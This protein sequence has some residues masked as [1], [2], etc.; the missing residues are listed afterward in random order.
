[1]DTLFSV[2]SVLVSSS[3]E[4]F[5]QENRW[6]EGGAIVETV[7]QGVHLRRIPAQQ[8]LPVALHHTY[9]APCL[10]AREQNRLYSRYGLG[11][12]AGLIVFSTARESIL[13]GKSCII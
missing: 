1:M 9:R 8:H 11:V 6:F 12:A 7:N 2:V 4:T 5:V 10:G 13:C 3:H